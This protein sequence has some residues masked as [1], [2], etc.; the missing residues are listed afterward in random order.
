MEKVIQITISEVLVKGRIVYRSPSDISVEITDPFIN[1]T[2]GLHIPY[3]A[4]SHASFQGNYGGKT[5]R[6][7]LVHLY[8]TLQIINIK[9]D[10]FKSSLHDYK[11]IF[12]I[13]GK[14]NDEQ[15]DFFFNKVIKLQLSRDLR[16]Q[17]VS[18]FEGGR[19][20]VK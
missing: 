16:E 9:E 7:L 11:K 5:A 18:I 15:V 14:L 1:I 2:T 13:D 12:N 8:R 4:R 10:I 3:F 20:Y 6:R 17:I 19:T